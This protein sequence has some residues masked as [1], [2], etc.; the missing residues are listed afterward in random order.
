VS[1]AL[2]VHLKCLIIKK[3]KTESLRRLSLDLQVHCDRL[4]LFKCL[5]E[6]LE[7]Q[8]K[9]YEQ[10]LR[11]FHRFHYEICWRDATTFHRLSDRSVWFVEK[12]FLKISR[13]TN[14]QHFGTFYGRQLTIRHMAVS[15]IL[16]GLYK[17]LFFPY[18]S[19]A[20]YRNSDGFYFQR[21]LIER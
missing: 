7:R 16:K 12:H 15:F 9:N 8:E 10:P 18:W 19:H 14:M 11:S 6:N 20:N 1:S 5:S 2:A 13:K 3:K 4:L 21:I 17:T